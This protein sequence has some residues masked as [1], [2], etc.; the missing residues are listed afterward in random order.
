MLQT[1]LLLLF[2]CTLCTMSSEINLLPS[3]YQI[4]QETS[5]NLN[6]KLVIQKTDKALRAFKKLCKCNPHALLANPEIKSKSEKLLSDLEK[7]MRNGS[8][9]PEGELFGLFIEENDLESK[10]GSPSDR[11]LLLESA[12][13]NT[14]FADRLCALMLHNRAKQCSSD[15]LAALFAVYFHKVQERN[16][17]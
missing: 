7:R 1:L 5:S 13:Q 17:N 16:P 14:L 10:I 8:T 11:F 6:K 12:W 4:W 3:T 15:A 2:S 9:D